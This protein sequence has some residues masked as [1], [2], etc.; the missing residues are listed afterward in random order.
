MYTLVE[1][2][3]VV[4][5]ALVVA[6]L[7]FLVAV[8]LISIKQLGILLA[9]TPVGVALIRPLTLNRWRPAGSSARP[10][11]F[12]S[13][14]PVP[15]QNPEVHMKKKWHSFLLPARDDT[16]QEQQ[17]IVGASKGPESALHPPES[18]LHPPDFDS[19]IA[20]VAD[21]RPAGASLLDKYREQATKH[22]GGE[23]TILKIVQMLQSDHIRALPRQTKRAAILVALQVAG[24]KVADVIDDA[25]QR[26]DALDNAERAREKALQEIETRK[27]Q[28]NRKLQA[29]VQSLVAEYD[30]RIQ[31]NNEE[32]S[33]E[34]DKFAE[35]RHAK[36]EEEQRIADALSYLLDE[37]APSK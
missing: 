3:T 11:E 27:E 32:V 5:A 18:A 31:R 6:G 28:A 33:A 36:V 2:L 23:Y 12:D 1:C 37:N 16:T 26:N 29:L 20:V 13:L 24:V 35:W 17:S 4:F 34:R 22:S 9:N 15:T 19:G 7:F 8:I 30:A 21:I 25:V 14:V 10:I